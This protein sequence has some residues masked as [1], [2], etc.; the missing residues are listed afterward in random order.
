ML[1]FPIK[2]KRMKTH[3]DQH[4]PPPHRSKATITR[5][6]TLGIC[7]LYYI[8]VLIACIIN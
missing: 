8:A 1:V 2:E 6:I 4:L 7:L 3:M 5:G